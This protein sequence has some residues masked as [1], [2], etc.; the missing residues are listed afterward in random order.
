DRI[1]DLVKKAGPA[2]ETS[3]ASRL[4]FAL[5]DYFSTAEHVSRMLISGERGES[6][7]SAIAEMQ[8][9]QKNAERVIQ[10]STQVGRGEINEA[11]D[12][13]QSSNRRASLFR[14]ITAFAA[15]LAMF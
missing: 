4:R 12:S 14:M 13:L 15:V 10:E 8:R 7:L 1:L 2:M 11:F 5:E 6:T 3:D 9:T